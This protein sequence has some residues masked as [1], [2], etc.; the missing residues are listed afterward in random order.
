MTIKEVKELKN[1]DL[2]WVAK[3]Q[4]E[5]RVMYFCEIDG[6]NAIMEDLSIGFPV[7]I[8][9][10]FDCLVALF[11]PVSLPAVTP[12]TREQIIAKN[13]YD[14]FGGPCNFSPLGDD[15]YDYCNSCY[16]ECNTTGENCWLRVIGKWLEEE[17]ANE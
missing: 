10:A 13:L 6:E 16:G 2:V 5:A 8:K 17:I 12:K 9:C 14:G 3:N 15:M 1:G 11:R 4:R 7:H